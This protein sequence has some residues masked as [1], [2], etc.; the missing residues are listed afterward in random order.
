MISDGL[1]SHCSVDALRGLVRRL[2]YR[3]GIVCAQVATCELKEVCF[4]N[5]VVLK[6][7]DI[8]E[9]VGEFGTILRQLIMK[10]LK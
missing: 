4:P 3:H 2:T 1:P 9:A 10:A 5:Y 7:N 8:A 6:N